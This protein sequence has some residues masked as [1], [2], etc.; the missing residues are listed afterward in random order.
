M[1][2]ARH[3][4]FNAIV[5]L[6]AFI[7]IAACTPLKPIP[8]SDDLP[9]LS[10]LGQRDSRPHSEFDA[11]HSPA[12]P[13]RRTENN[14]LV[15]PFINGKDL[16]WF[17]LDTGASGMTITSRAAKRAGLIAI[18]ST[19]IQ[20]QLPTTVYQGQTLTLGQLTLQNPQFAGLNM[21]WAKQYFGERIEGICGWDVFAH[22]II[23]IDM[24]RQT[25]SVHDPA[26]YHAPSAQWQPFE[27]VNGR[28]HVHAQLQTQSGKTGDGHFLLDTGYSE[29]VWLFP[30]AVEQ[31]DLF[32]D[33]YGR[34]KKMIMVDAS[35]DVRSLQLEWFEFAGRRHQNVEAVM[36]VGGATTRQERIPI[37]G[38]IGLGLLG[39]G[40]IV[41]D[42]ENSRMAI[43]SHE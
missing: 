33:A 39:D 27:L 43:F 8:P 29:H 17:I 26:S 16:G 25:V 14:L 3:T 32:D 30:T 13:L 18:A 42:Y 41:I 34:K 35:A 23:E 12:V 38:M 40:R 2:H 6:I 24:Q 5:C 28:P 11:T 4:V 7:A 1:N 9:R 36:S 31:F 37:A 19:S 15:R 22:S 21:P 10:E 20:G